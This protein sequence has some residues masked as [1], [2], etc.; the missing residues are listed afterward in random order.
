MYDII[1]SHQRLEDKHLNMLYNRD[2]QINL[3]SNEGFGLGKL[4]DQ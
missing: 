4:F 1:F 2:V 3:Q